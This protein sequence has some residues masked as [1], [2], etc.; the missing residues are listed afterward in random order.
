MAKKYKVGYKT[1]NAKLKVTRHHLAKIK[2]MMT[3]AKDKKD[4]EGQIKA[5]DLIIAACKGGKMSKSYPSN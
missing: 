1:I 4:I 5:M 3:S 2:K